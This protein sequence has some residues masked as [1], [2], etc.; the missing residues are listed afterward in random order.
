M[1][2]LPAAV[3]VS[4]AVHA[5][6]LA[7]L[8]AGEPEAPILAG[9]GSEAQRPAPDPPQ[10]PPPEPPPQ[11][12]P[13]PP[14]IEVVFLDERAM[15][16]ITATIP[17]PPAYP[18]AESAAISTHGAERAGTASAHDAAAPSGAE[19]PGRTPLMTMRR[20]E[21]RGGLSGAFLD[22]FLARSKPAEPVPDL[23]GARIDA[24]IADL[25]A[26]L[27]NP[28]HGSPGA[29]L[30]RLVELHD[31]RK[32]VELRRQRD[33]TYRAD[34]TGFT[35]KID[36]DGKA[37]LADKPSVRFQGPILLMD[38]TDMAMRTAGIDPYAS[39]KLRFLDR[40]RDQRAAIAREHRR[41][42]LG[43]SAHLMRRN[44]E[45]LWASTPDLG[46]RKQG[47]FELWDEC[48]ETGSAELVAGG[49]D[50][51]R[52]VADFIKVKLTGASAY[53]A[54]EL[55]RLNARRRSRAVF[56]P[57]DPNVHRERES[58]GRTMG[59]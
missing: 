40:T 35:A 44:L 3:L 49:E 12:P 55:A 53:T 41:E 34:S 48:A 6:A 14:P 29:D 21:L 57:Y 7:W 10:P 50:A 1:R 17:L 28:G 38:V 58:D 27:R 52:V 9:L 25:R 59:S 8:T 11:P 54:D 37:H 39:E 46:A 30:V 47:L 4:V 36:R 32:R 22:D 31:Q 33:G 42:Q 23:P 16:A 20:P 51:R 24:E 15:R 19:P 5:A 26:R 43:Q 56:A 18:G 2:E 13:E 45:R